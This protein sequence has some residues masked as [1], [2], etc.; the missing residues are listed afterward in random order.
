[1]YYFYT[2]DTLSNASIRY[3]DTFECRVII[4]IIWLLIELIK[5]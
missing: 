5:K 3:I 4:I 1:M 2:F